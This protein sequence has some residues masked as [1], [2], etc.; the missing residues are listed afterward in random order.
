MSWALP[1]LFIQLVTNP[2]SISESLSILLGG[3]L[4]LAL[5]GISLLLVRSATSRRISFLLSRRT[6]I[7]IHL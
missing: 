2:H 5:V 6:R 4:I 3:S 7:G 1:F